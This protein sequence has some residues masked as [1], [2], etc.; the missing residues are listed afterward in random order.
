M[1]FLLSIFLL[2]SRMT[3]SLIPLASGTF[4]SDPTDLPFFNGQM[5]C[6][7]GHN[8][9]VSEC[10]FVCDDGF[11]LDGD[12]TIRCRPDGHWSDIR[13]ICRREYPFPAAS[14]SPP[15][16]NCSARRDRSVES[17]RLLSLSFRCFSG[18]DVLWMSTSA[19]KSSVYEISKRFRLIR[20]ADSETIAHGAV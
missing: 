7:R 5:T 12:P 19:S 9:A 15:V 4:C 2:L 17:T 14:R 6:E 20:R 1:A 8:G 16:A 18:R 3:L 13:P 11:V 10:R